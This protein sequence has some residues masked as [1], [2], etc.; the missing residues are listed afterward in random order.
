VVGGEF[1]DLGTL[2]LPPIVVDCTYPR[3]PTRRVWPGRVS[4]DGPF[5]RGIDYD[6]IGNDTMTAYVHWCGPGEPLVIRA[7]EA[8]ARV[9][10]LQHGECQTVRLH[11]G[12]S[13]APDLV[14]AREDG[15]ALTLLSLPLPVPR[16][17]ERYLP[18]GN[19]LVL[20]DDQ[21]T[22]YD[23]GPAAGTTLLTLRWLTAKPLQ[24]DY[25]VSTRFLDAEGRWLGVHDIQPSLGAIPTLKWV[26][27]NQVVRDPHPLIAPD[28]HPTRYALVVY[29]RFRLTPLKTLHGD[30]VSYQLQ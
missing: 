2:S 10:R 1:Q 17:G 28:T 25:A 27:H 18:Y 24:Q 7:S 13:A 3:L 8:K 12:S 20:I 9:D 26:V 21:V 6:V 16:D 5:L 4:P 15:T 22:T 19:E 30:L 29:E 23:T 14:L 11:L